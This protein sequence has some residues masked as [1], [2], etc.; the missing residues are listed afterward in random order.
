MPSG[1]LQPLLEEQVTAFI[2]ARTTWTPKPLD[3][4]ANSRLTFHP[5]STKSE[6]GEESAGSA[7]ELREEIRKKWL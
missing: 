1:V 3:G 7:K 4:T 2:E 6:G 5:K